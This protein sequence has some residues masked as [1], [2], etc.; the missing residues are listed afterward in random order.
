MRFFEFAITP[1]T[2]SSIKDLEY[3]LTNA[4]VDPN[5]LQKALD[6]LKKDSQEKQ[7]SLKQP[8][9]SPTQN[10]NVQSAP[11]DQ[12]QALSGEKNVKE[13]AT[14]SLKNEVI[15][16]AKEASPDKLEKVIY[17][18][19]LDSFKDM[20]SFIIKSKIKVKANAI[21]D[22][23]H[24]AI[25]DLAGKTSVKS[26]TD[27][28]ND[29]KEG[30]VIDAPLMITGKQGIVQSIPITREDYLPIV[31]RLLDTNLGGASASGKG[32]FGL[33]FAGTDATKGEK[34]ITIG[35]IDIEVK[36][37]HRKTDFFFKGQTGFE[38]VHT[39][40]A[41]IKLVNALNSVGGEFQQTNQVGKGGIAQINPKT[42][43]VL[44]PFFMKLGQK[45]VVN[46]L[47]NIISE[48][49]SDHDVSEF[50]NDIANS[51]NSNG[52]IDYNKLIYA[53]SKISFYYYQQIE[54]HPG[55]LMLNITSVSYVYQ[56]TAGD[57]AELV[58]K[59]IIGTT[60]AIDFRTSTKGSL[61]FKI[62]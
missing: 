13:T 53:T 19:K 12:T 20:A 18:I 50:N 36:A 8:E 17:Y 26:M 35:G 49:H 29:C 61:T 58:S 59:G 25:S 42:L 2:S 23:I 10:P 3:L 16:F 39:K 37:T 43:E 6:F 55:V 30:G 14:D 56:K 33:A 34:D 47:V 40:N 38:P 44:N 21:T 51:V 32:E 60:S 46:L 27:F 41:L 9:T 11:Q 54:K 52:S 4:D 1:Q 7:D 22:Q 5:T 31:K 15:Q 24:L 57:F 28:L 62:N 48:I 45:T